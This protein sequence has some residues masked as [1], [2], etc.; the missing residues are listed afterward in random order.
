LIIKRRKEGD[1]SQTSFQKESLRDG[2]SLHSAAAVRMGSAA[3]FEFRSY[4]RALPCL[5]A[6]RMA[7]VSNGLREPLRGCFWNEPGWSQRAIVSAADALSALF[8]VVGCT[9]G[10]VKALRLKLRDK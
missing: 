10:L 4:K 5:K 8:E 1:K 2:D 9:P 7:V 3:V 6:A